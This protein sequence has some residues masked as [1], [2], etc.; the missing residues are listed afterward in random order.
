MGLFLKGLLDYAKMDSSISLC[1]TSSQIAHGK[2]IN[3]I[4][5]AFLDS[6]KCVSLHVII[7]L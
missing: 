1:V 3:L 5:Q 6:F 7:D 4:S 2:F